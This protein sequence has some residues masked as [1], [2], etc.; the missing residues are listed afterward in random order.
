MKKFIAFIQRPGLILSTLPAAYQSLWVYKM[1]LYDVYIQSIQFLC[2]C[3]SVYIYRYVYTC[4]HTHTYLQITQIKT[5]FRYFYQRYAQQIFYSNLQIVF[6][7]VG[8]L[9]CC[10]DF[11]FILLRTKITLNVALHFLTVF[12]LCFNVIFIILYT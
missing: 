1:Q 9:L 12:C 3:L 11:F 5:Q 2:L 10:A 4:I 8:C 6:H 7:F